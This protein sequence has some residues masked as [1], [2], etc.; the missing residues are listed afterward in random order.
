MRLRCIDYSDE[1]QLR[2]IHAKYF[3]SEFEFPDLYTNFL[4]SFVVTD[5]DGK[6]VVGGGIR[7]IVEAVIIT[8]RDI[9]IGKRRDALIEMLRMSAFGT[10]SRGYKELHAFVQDDKWLRHLEKAGFRK[11]KGQSLVL[12]V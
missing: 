7:P 11:T 3:N 6:I 2:T 8:N 9:S 12:S 1:E 10:A 4:S 5:D